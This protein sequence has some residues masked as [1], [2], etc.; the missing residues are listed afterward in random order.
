[1]KWKKIKEELKEKWAIFLLFGLIIVVVNT[2]VQAIITNYVNSRMEGPACRID[3]PM[4]EFSIGKNSYFNLKYLL[5]NL[6]GNDLLIDGIDAYCYWKEESNET[7]QNIIFNPPSIDQISEP[8]ELDKI[9]F[10]KSEIKSSNCKSPNKEGKYKIRVVARTTQGQ[11][12]G[13][14][15]MNIK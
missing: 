1:M 7:K 9:T 6:R 13:E 5:I 12:E 10:S 14:V 2:G 15:I 8:R 4:D 11:C 3:F